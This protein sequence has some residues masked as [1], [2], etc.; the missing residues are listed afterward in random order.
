[1]NNQT[2]F[3][4]AHR[5]ARLTR[6]IVGDYQ[7]AFTIALRE[8]NKK[9]VVKS[10][11]EKID[12]VFAVIGCLLLAVLVIG[13]VCGLTYLLGIVI[14]VMVGSA[15]VGL[16][17]FLFFASLVSSGMVTLTANEIKFIIEYK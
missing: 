1:M 12:N 10:L 9:K 4:E 14:S 11:S 7:V 3:L 17:F 13:S 2:K 5:V 6:H 16:V 8:L 15:Y